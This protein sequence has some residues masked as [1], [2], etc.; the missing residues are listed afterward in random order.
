M[1]TIIKKAPIDTKQLATEKS[2]D[3]SQLLNF[4]RAFSLLALDA[5]DSQLGLHLNSGECKFIRCL[6]SL[7]ICLSMVSNCKIL[8]EYAATALG[9][10]AV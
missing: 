7:V 9:S 2:S 1:K 6:D 8:E 4:R 10:L 3:S 5:A